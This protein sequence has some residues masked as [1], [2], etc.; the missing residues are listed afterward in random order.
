M[1]LIRKILKMLGLNDDHLYHTRS[2]AYPERTP[3]HIEMFPNDTIKSRLETFKSYPKHLRPKPKDLAQAG[4]FYTQD[5]DKVV[6]FECG[7]G[8]N[9]WEPDDDA[10]L[11]HK[12]F[13]PNC[14]FI[15]NGGV[16]AFLE[17]RESKEEEIEVKKIDG[18]EE[19]DNLLCVICRERT[20]NVL[21]IPCRHLTTCEEC[22][23]ELCLCTVCGREERQRI[24]LS[25]ETV[26]KRII[27]NNIDIKVKFSH[28]RNMT[29]SLL[30]SYANN[31]NLL[32]S[33]KDEIAA[34]LLMQNY[35]QR[36]NTFEGW[37]VS[38][39]GKETLAEDGF[40]YF[41]EGDKVRCAFC[42]VE[43]GRWERGDVP[44][45]EHRRWNPNCP[46]L[47][48]SVRLNLCI[49]VDDCGYKM[50]DN[51]F[52]KEEGEERNLSVLLNNLG[53]E[54]NIT[55]SHP[56]YALFDKRL[57]SFEHWPVSIKQK[58]KDL[59][60]A[61]YYYTGYGDQT[62]CFHCGLGLKAW[63]EDDDPWEQHALWSEKCVFLRLQKGVEY[64]K[65]IKEKHHSGFMENSIPSSPTSSVQAQEMCA[66]LNIDITKRRNS[67]VQTQN[68]IIND[69]K[70]AVTAASSS[71][72]S[73]SSNK[74]VPLCGICYVNE[75]SIV[76]L[77][78]RHM[79]ACV[80]C[81]ATATTCP[82][83][84]QEVRACVKAFMA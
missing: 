67:S 43:I 38:F 79:I 41:G 54:T 72:S 4:F 80:D 17:L 8:L 24:I 77:P 81:A 11:E 3:H 9:D 58:P 39:I 34:N 51:R 23:D 53:I 49:G 13:S 2:R 82:V 37:S 22:N 25:Y 48:N 56:N 78:C 7:L 74:S 36:L 15:K 27:T 63:Q 18:D 12:K 76:N 65:E 16:K 47:N 29:S 62:V 20:R 30:G 31:H 10:W 60:S 42:G 26:K 64:I 46:L 40:Y 19:T 44:N 35:I 69:T 52:R 21:S 84:R 70:E 1:F 66:S 59:A 32:T 33:I 57:A 14:M 28:I 83:C 50:D 5:A 75:R 61:G 45:A 73:S 68:G 6:C 55:V 71:S